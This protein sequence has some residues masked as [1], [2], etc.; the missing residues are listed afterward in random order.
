MPMLT[1]GPSR[2][3]QV[4]G[5]IVGWS[6]LIAETLIPTAEIQPIIAGAAGETINAISTQQRVID[7]AA[8]Y[9]WFALGACLRIR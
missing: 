8:V 4:S 6:S 1:P 2:L 3:R 7:S 9:R 5:R